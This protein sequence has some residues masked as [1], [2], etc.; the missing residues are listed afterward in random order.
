LY[1]N[2]IIFSKKEALTEGIFGQ[3]LIWLLELLYHLEN[4]NKINNSTKIIFDINTLNNDNLIPNF[5]L[6]NKLYKKNSLVNPVKISLAGFKENRTMSEF[7]FNEDSFRIASDIFHKYFK[8]SELVAEKL[9]FL[10]INK[11][12]L[13]VH[14]RGTDKN[15]DNGQTNPVLISEMILIVEDFM[16]S[17]EEVN[18]I[19]CCSDEKEFIKRMKSK[20]KNKI[21]EYP[22]LRA[23]NSK[24]NA[25]F[26]TGSSI[27]TTRRKRNQ[28]TISSIIDM[29]LL[30]KCNSVIKSSSALSSF[31]KIIDPSVNLYAVSAMKKKWFPTGVV[32]VY[33]T[34][35]ETISAILTRTMKDDVFQNLN[36]QK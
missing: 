33:K 34:K 15:Y 36:K 11:N 23:H 32:N 25:F 17:T 9:F 8:F 20:F 29:L 31:S 35:S 26:R 27:W 4:N 13:G 21:I 12:V 10:N 2:V 6:P 30:S 28:L 24:N 14:Y 19:F 3:C 16:N 5:I 22:Q 1:S 7:K 18:S